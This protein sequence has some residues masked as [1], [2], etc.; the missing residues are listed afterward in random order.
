MKH[1]VL[2]LPSPTPPVLLLPHLGRPH[3]HRAFPPQETHRDP[4]QRPGEAFQLLPVTHLNPLSSTKQCAA[5]IIQLG[6]MREA[7]H[8]WPWPWAWRLTCQGHSPWSEFSPPT[9]RDCLVNDRR[10]QS[11]RD[12]GRSHRVG[13]GAGAAC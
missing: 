8:K 12:R 4:T 2:P 5:D 6:E 9:T 1:S 10:P 3:R 7:P 11:G 13:A